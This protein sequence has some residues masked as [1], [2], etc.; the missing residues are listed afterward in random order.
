MPKGLG[1]GSHLYYRR[2]ILVRTAVAR[3]SVP[4]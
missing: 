4:G 2:C 1:M 3:F